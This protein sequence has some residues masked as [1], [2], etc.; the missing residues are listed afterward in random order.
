MKKAASQ[1]VKQ[2]PWTWIPSLYFIQGLPYIM[3]MSVAVT[4]YKTLEISNTEIALYTSWLYLPWVIKPIWSPFV[5]LVKTTR[6]WTWLMQVVI[7]GAL[8]AVALTLPMA[9][10]L[11]Y[12]LAFF[13]L[14]AFSSAT[15]DI[16]ADGFYMKALSDSNQ[17]FFLGIRSSFYRVAMLTG[18]GAIVYIAGYLYEDMG[19]QYDYAWMWAFLAL[20]GLI[21]TGGLYHMFLLPKVEEE[22]Q[23]DYTA[24]DIVKGLQDTFVTFF[25][26]K[27]IWLSIAFLLTFRLGEAQLVKLNIPFM[28]DE[29]A[30]GGLNM[31]AKEQGIIYG[32]IGMVALTLGGILGGIALS[33][34]GLKAWIMWMVLAINLPNGVYVLLSAFLPDTLQLAGL[35][36]FLNLFDTF[37]EGV[38]FTSE[39]TRLFFISIGIATEQFFYGFGFAGYLMYMIYISQGQF[40]TSHYALCTGFMAMGMMLPGMAS[41][42]I[43]EMVGYTSFFIWVLVSALP[44]LLVTPLLKVD[45]NFGK[46]TA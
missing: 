44:C 40:K 46:K 41:G 9:S 24:K 32:T 29:F 20:G 33:K 45:P 39:P 1:K 30:K 23:E 18:Q 34:K 28:L 6:W 11:Q 17:A 26:K 4:M 16:A 2:N 37:F 22:K 14:V 10:F 13:W 21:L 12:S 42:Y 19:M 7:G 8:A 5:D 35:T 15:H 36:D 43:Q 25:S 31:T 38:G 27:G 3:V